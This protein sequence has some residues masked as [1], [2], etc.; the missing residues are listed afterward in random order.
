[1]CLFFCKD[2]LKTSKIGIVLS[3]VYCKV[4]LQQIPPADCAPLA[5][6]LF[7]LLTMGFTHGY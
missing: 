4:G 6:A 5:L 1:M 7:I 2:I 3:V